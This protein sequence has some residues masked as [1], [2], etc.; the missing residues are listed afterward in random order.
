MAKQN[1][2]VLGQARHLQ[3][4]PD[5]HKRSSDMV[6]VARAITAETTDTTA[7]MLDPVVKI[8]IDLAKLWGAGEEIDARLTEAYRQKDEIKQADYNDEYRDNWALIDAH[9]ALL[10]SKASRSIPGALVQL[11]LLDGMLDVMKTSEYASDQDQQADFRRM[12][13]LVASI[14][15]VLSEHACGVDPLGPI[16]RGTG[17]T[18]SSNKHEAPNDAPDPIFA[19]IETQRAAEACFDASI[20]DDGE[21]DE[22]V[23]NESSRTLRELCETEPKTAAGIAAVLRYLQEIHAV[24]TAVFSDDRSTNALL[25]LAKAAERLAS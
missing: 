7:A 15:G 17:R 22:E 10:A 11:S 13:R 20:D 6:Q 24:E 18:A 19:L 5:H 3:G 2:A 4:V 8:G 9:T 12:A 16:Y 25:T 1:K 21:V 14:A 23:R